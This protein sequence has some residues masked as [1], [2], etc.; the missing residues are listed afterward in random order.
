MG[1]DY[2]NCDMCNRIL[3]D[4]GSYESFEILSVGSLSTCNDCGKELK[5]KLTLFEPWTECFLAVTSTGK[6]VVCRGLEAAKQL[7][8]SDPATKFGLHKFTH[9]MSKDK[10]AAWTGGSNNITTGEA[11]SPSSSGNF[12]FTVMTN[13]TEEQL[14]RYWKSQWGVMCSN[15]LIGWYDHQVRH[16]PLGYQYRTHNETF[17]RLDDYR[18]MIWS[19]L[20]RYTDEHKL[21][22]TA[23]LI[24]TSQ[25]LM[26]L[27]CDPDKISAYWFDSLEEAEAARHSGDYVTSDCGLVWRPTQAYID[28]R[29]AELRRQLA[30]KEQLINKLSAIDLDHLDH[31]SPDYEDIASTLWCVD[32]VDKEADKETSGE[33]DADD[34]SDDGDE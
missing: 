8:A 32:V 26:S 3:C 31:S 6:R 4:G 7:L 23:V 22:N 12:L 11:V 30:E 5:R 1:V 21:N 9:G 20:K 33:N 10:I 16:Y 13:I 25:Y 28:D 17:F 19:Y 2:F 27:F 14:D 18:V 24:T 15:S 34:D 29:V